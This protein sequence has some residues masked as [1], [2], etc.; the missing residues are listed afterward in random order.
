[1]KTIFSKYNKG[2]D[3]TVCIEIIPETDFEKEFIKRHEWERTILGNPIV[4]IVEEES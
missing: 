1:M 3:G 4:S 2:K